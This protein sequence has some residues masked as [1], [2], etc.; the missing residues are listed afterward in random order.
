MRLFRKFFDYIIIFVLIYTSRE[1]V[2]FGTNSNAVTAFLGYVAPAVVLMIL[3]LRK[4]KNAVCEYNKQTYDTTIIII[5]L[6]MITM[7]SNFDINV[8]YGYEI[9]LC[10]TAYHLVNQIEFERFAKVYNDILLSLSLFAVITSLAYIFYPGYVGAFPT[11]TNKGGY[12]FYFLGLSVIPG[13]IEGVLFRLFGIFREP[14]V[15]II[16]IN[17]ALLFELFVLNGKKTPRVLLL[18]L[19]VGMTLST[20]GFI[21]TFIILMTYLLRAHNNH[22]IISLFF[23]VLVLVS[24]YFIIQNDFIYAALFNKFSATDSAST[25]ARFGSI[26]YNIKMILDNPLGSFFGLGYQSVED[27]FEGLESLARGQGHNTNTL[28]KEL[29]V[30]GFCFFCYFLVRIYYFSKGVIK[31][32]S[33]QTL[34][35]FLALVMMLSNEDLTVDFILYVIVLYSSI[36][37]SNSYKQNDESLNT[38]YVLQ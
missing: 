10:L 12:D 38:T 25:G 13:E 16:F 1:T 8:K 14:G 33:W 32:K 29:S 35:V 5:F 3:V 28:L 9:V 20:A 22:A 17:I 6:I 15:A 37:G 27:F 24:A 2:L 34:F 11:I 7:L 18:V 26:T 4:G 36:I 30:H 19:T 21:I 31:E 23:I